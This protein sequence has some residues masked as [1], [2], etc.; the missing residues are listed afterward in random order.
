MNLNDVSTIQ[1]IESRH[2]GKIKDLTKGLAK[3]RQV[4]LEIIPAN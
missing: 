2:S 3:L 4:V 1:L